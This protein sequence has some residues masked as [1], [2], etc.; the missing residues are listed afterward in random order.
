MINNGYLA[1]YS[2]K[3]IFKKTQGSD[4]F[5]HGLFVDDMMHIS[6]GSNCGRDLAGFGCDAVYQNCVAY[7]IIE[8]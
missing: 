3:T 4:Y 1:V 6:N 2:E 7:N 5:I 8:F